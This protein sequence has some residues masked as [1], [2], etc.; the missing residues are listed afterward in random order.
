MGAACGL[1]SSFFLGDNG[2]VLFTGTVVGDP[3][4][5]GRPDGADPRIPH[6][7]AN[8]PRIREVSVSLSVPLK[9]A[10][11]GMSLVAMPAATETQPIE[12]AIF[13]AADDRRVFLWGSPGGPLPRELA[14]S[15]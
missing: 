15:L 3:A 8:L 6:K 7:L 9:I 1:D 5:F 4:P 11:P 12:A 14:L 10:L 2:N 13:R